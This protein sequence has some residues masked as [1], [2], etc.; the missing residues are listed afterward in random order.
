MKRF[1]SKTTEVT[2]LE[3]LHPEMPAD[4]V[5]ISDEVFMRVIANPDP[6]K[7]RSHD[8]KGFPVLIDRPAPTMEELAEPER[9]W[10][11]A[12]LS[13]TDRLV[14]RHRDE[15]DDNSATT[16]AEDQYKGLQAYRSALRDWPEAKAFPDSAKRPGAPDW[17]SSLL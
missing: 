10:R 17:F 12:E 2:Y 3:G 7:V 1:Y 4:S 15:V 6:S 13:M 16:L 11:D 5:E 9:R 8:N 14:A